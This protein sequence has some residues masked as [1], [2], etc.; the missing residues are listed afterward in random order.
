MAEKITNQVLANELKNLTTA[1]NKLE[2]KFDSFTPTNVLELKLKAL[3]V[4]ILELQ[5]K[6]KELELDIQLLRR[7]IEKLKKRNAFQVWITGSLSALF[8]IILY[9]LAT[10]YLNNLGG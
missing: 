3:D 8:G 1:I 10:S 6:D 4:K 5:A 7:S 2:Q 9:V